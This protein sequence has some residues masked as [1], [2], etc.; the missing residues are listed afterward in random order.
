MPEKEDIRIVFLL[1]SIN[2]NYK[3][4]KSGGRV[5]SCNWGCTSWLMRHTMFV[6]TNG[7]D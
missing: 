1:T 3:M 2:G 4:T 6:K 7:G 5:G